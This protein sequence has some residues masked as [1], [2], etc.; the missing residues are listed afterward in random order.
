M[1]QPEPPDGAEWLADWLEYAVPLR[2][3]DL[4]HRIATEHLTQE[5][6]IGVAR[7]GGA[8]LGTYGDV[9]QY[10]DRR[11]RNGRQR[12]T[13]IRCTDDLVDGVAAAVIL[14]GP[15]GTT[16]FGQQF[17]PSPAAETTPPG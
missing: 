1:R 9:M 4:E 6:L 11:P 3:R 17:R 12:N 13:V 7:R 2:I 16:V 10:S 14:A 15:E 8:S 5:W